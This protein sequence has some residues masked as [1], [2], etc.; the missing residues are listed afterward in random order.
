NCFKI[1]NVPSTLRIVDYTH[2]QTGSVHDVTVF[3]HTAAYK[4]PDWLYGLILHIL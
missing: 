1:G 3:E 4:F 2:G